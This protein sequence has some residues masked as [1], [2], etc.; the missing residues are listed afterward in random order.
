M[1]IAFRGGDAIG[2]SFEFLEKGFRPSD[3][4]CSS[5]FGSQNKNMN[6]PGQFTPV[7]GL[8]M[9]FEEQGAGEP[10]L[11]IHGGSASIESFY[12]Q[13]PAFT[14]QYRVI[15]ADSRGHGRTGDTEGEYS[16]PLMAEDFAQF[17]QSRGLGPVSIIGWSDGGIIG[18]HLAIHFPQLVKKLVMI[19]ACADVSGQTEE[20]LESVRHGKPEEHP[21]ILIELYQQLSPDGPAH[22]PVF[23]EKLRRMWLGSPHYTTEQLKSVRCPV[24]VMVGEHDIV[25]TEHTAEMAHALPNAQICVISGA[26]HFAPVEN[27]AAVNSAILAFLKAGD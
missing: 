14:G 1:F 26:S 9:Y 7:N 6:H 5:V 17:I 22:W 19:G 24:L 18:L 16:Y 10:L 23:Y 25:K 4:R 11:F 21:A 2:K 15:A 27:P 3:L 8:Q 13:I 12:Q 20:F